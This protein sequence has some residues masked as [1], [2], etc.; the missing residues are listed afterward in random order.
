MDPALAAK[1]QQDAARYAL[2]RFHNPRID[3][4]DPNVIATYIALKAKNQ[5]V[6]SSQILYALD[7]TKDELV[8]ASALYR[9]WC[10]P[11]P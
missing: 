5:R 3:P 8:R 2:S 1:K 4:K 6:S 9:S 10:S 11:I 7:N